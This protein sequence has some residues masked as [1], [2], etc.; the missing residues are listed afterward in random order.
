MSVLLKKI[1]KRQSDSYEKIC[2]ILK[3]E[4]KSNEWIEIEMGHAEISSKTMRRWLMH[5]GLFDARPTD[6]Y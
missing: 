2:L 4:R 6:F 5:R 3:F 1:K